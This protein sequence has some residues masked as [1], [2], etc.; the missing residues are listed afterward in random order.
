MTPTTPRWIRPC[1]GL[2]DIQIILIGKNTCRQ[3]VPLFS[4]A[5]QERCTISDRAARWHIN[6]M[7]TLVLVQTFLR[8]LSSHNHFIIHLQ[9]EKRCEWQCSEERP[10]KIYSDLIGEVLQ[11]GQV[12]STR[13]RCAIEQ[14]NVNISVHVVFFSF[15]QMI[16]IVFDR[17]LT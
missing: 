6:N 14:M 3:G 11:K 16:D 13:N 9:N 12:S 7:S 10:R 1:T 5:Q 17:D 2:E 8:R 4:C 15:L